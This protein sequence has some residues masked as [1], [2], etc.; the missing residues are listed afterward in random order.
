VSLMTVNGPGPIASAVTTS[1]AR[2]P[3]PP[4]PRPV[5]PSAP[6]PAVSAPTGA[7]PQLWSMLT[8]DEQAFFA[9]H[10]R[11]GS[12]TYG[13]PQASPQTIDAPRGQRIDLRV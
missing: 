9:E 12:L 2:Q 5:E 4:P 11:L 1:I 10:A 3:P 7:D 8:P 6:T 13:P